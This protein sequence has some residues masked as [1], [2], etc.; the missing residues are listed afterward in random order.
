MVIGFSMHAY[1]ERAKSR[2]AQITRIP[3][4]WARHPDVLAKGEDVGPPIRKGDF[5]LKHA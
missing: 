2:I 4:F 3:L 5:R 1:K